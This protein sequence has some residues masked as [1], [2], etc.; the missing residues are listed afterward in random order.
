MKKKEEKEITS[1][2]IKHKII[3]SFYSNGMG[4]GYSSDD[5]Y[6]DFVQFPQAEGENWADTTRIFLTPKTFKDLV[7]LLKER[8]DKYEKDYGE[9]KVEEEK[10][11]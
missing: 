2:D 3:N 10:S 4:S 8:L 5:F 7:N 11:E 1:D 6:I 9:I